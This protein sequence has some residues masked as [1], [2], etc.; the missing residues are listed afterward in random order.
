MKK[1][2]ISFFAIVLIQFS[3]GQMLNPVKWTTKIE[4]TGK[5]EYK[6][7][8]SAK[9]EKNWHIYTQ[10]IV[11]DGPIPTSL[12]FDKTN[13]D[14]QLIGKPTENGTKIHSGHDPVFDI[15]LKY[16]ENDMVLEQKLKVLKNTKL[17][18]AMEYMSCDDSRCVGPLSEDFEFDLTLSG[19]PQKKN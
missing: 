2:F 13:K 4:Q 6:L 19:D 1:F 17:K 7:I 9:V 18:V 8:F 3:F 11:G 15:D 12:T 16:F 10:T 14:V 5:G